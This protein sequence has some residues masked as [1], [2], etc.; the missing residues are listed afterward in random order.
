MKNYLSPL[1]SSWKANS[2]T[3]IL[4][5][6]PDNCYLLEAEHS[7]EFW[8]SKDREIVQKRVTEPFSL[9]VSCLIIQK[10]L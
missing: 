2:H 9:F 4:I 1:K 7:I 10:Y 6:Q 3:R 8:G 5:I